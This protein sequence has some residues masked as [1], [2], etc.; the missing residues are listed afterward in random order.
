MVAVPGGVAQWCHAH[1]IACL[2]SMVAYTHDMHT[3]SE[4]ILLGYKGDT[5]RRKIE[6]TYF[7]PKTWG[8]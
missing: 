2:M 1:D 3:F 7:D 6:G 5:T 8:E 4:S